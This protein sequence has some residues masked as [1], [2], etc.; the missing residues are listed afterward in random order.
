MAKRQTGKPSESAKKIK[1][2]KRAV[3]DLKVPKDQE[4]KGGAI[5]AI[6]KQ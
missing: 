2:P 6:P 3:K 5:Q 1:R 4:V